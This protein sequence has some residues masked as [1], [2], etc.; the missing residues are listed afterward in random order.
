MTPNKQ[1]T[2]L[3]SIGIDKATNRLIDKL[4]KRYSLK[5]GEIV[6]LA[7]GYID[8]ASINP[9]E[10]PE[11]TKAELAKINK[12]QDDLIRFIRHF[13]EEQLN[14]MIRATNSIAVRFE[15]IVKDFGDMLAGEIETSRELQNNVL[16]KLSEVFNQHVE[17]V[18]N[19]GKQITTLS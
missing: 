7:F 1:K 14:P 16:K 9:S 5:K 15:T 19:Q 3:T 4:C 18:N 8:K 6:R 17:V 2:G 10:P 11:S 12:R 13:E